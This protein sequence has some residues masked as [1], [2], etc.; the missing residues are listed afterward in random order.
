MHFLCVEPLETKKYVL[1]FTKN[2]VLKFHLLLL[3]PL[4]IARRT[5][6]KTESLSETAHAW[7][8]AVSSTGSDYYKHKRQVNP[9]LTKLLDHE[10]IVLLPRL[11]YVSCAGA[12][13]DL[14]WCI[15]Q[16]RVLPGSIHQIY[17]DTGL[18]STAGSF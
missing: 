16:V 4:I 8:L 15:Q 5:V 11:L 18:S 2:L 3:G 12:L 10:Q 13:R 7:S 1:K 6:Q 17:S 14:T 9:S